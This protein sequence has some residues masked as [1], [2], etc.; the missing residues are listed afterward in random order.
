MF[1]FEQLTRY[2]S[3]HVQSHTASAGTYVVNQ[4]NYQTNYFTIIKNNSQ[5]NL[6]G[7][8]GT[9]GVMSTGS[10][11]WELQNMNGTS[12]SGIGSDRKVSSTASGSASR[13]PPS[14]YVAQAPDFFHEGR[15]FKI[16]AELSDDVDKEIHEK[17]FILLDSS[18]TEGKGV[19]VDTIERLLTGASRNSVAVIGRG[20]QPD[21]AHGRQIHE[22]NLDKYK[23]IYLDDVGGNG[24]KDR[25]A[26]LDHSYNIPFPKYPCQDLGILEQESLDRLR[27]CFIEY[28]AIEWRLIDDLK[29]LCERRQALKAR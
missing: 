12:G 18:N 1:E 24:P 22:P 8:S 29:E 6:G 4:A 11:S 17:E 25:Y 23:K 14:E 5:N 19:R 16:W 2:S 26:R 3:T 9:F 13:S 20:S 15:Y 28:M 7:A 10:K 21:V 27:L